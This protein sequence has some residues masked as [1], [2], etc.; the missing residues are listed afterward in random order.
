ML[1]AKA[2]SIAKPKDV[3]VIVVRENQVY[4]R[5]KQGSQKA[6]V[7]GVKIEGGEIKIESGEGREIIRRMIQ[8]VTE[9][10]KGRLKIQGVGYRAKLEEG[11]VKLTIGYKDEK[12]VKIGKGVGIEITGNGTIITGRSAI[13]TELRQT[14]GKIELVRPARKDKYKGKGIVA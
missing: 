4:V 5:G 11:K 1:K 9:G 7:E 3:D 10:Y 8:G 12:E 13:K 2:E 6:I 14:L